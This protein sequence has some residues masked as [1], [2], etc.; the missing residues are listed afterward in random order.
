VTAMIDLRRRQLLTLA[1]LTP[2]VLALSQP[3]QAAARGYGAGYFPNFLLR[4]QDDEEVRFYDD[5]IKGK[6]V[7]I[8]FTYASCHALCPLVTANLVRVQRLLGSRVGRDVFMYSLTL[9][10]EEDTPAV[11]KRHMQTHGVGPGWWFLTGERQDIE[12]LRHRFGLVDLDPVVDADPSQHSGMIR[13]GNEPYERW[14]ACRGRERPEWIAKE[15]LWL[16]GP[17]LHAA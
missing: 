17:K 13:I 2:A 4:T 1:A 14:S 3:R 16:E 6:L 15:I 10:P 5:L 12:L 11:L 7:V 9:K 8:Q